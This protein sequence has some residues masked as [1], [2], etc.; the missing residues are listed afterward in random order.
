MVVVSG[1]VLW[2]GNHPLQY[3][4]CWCGGGGGCLSVSICQWMRGSPSL[5]PR[6]T[7]GRPLVAYIYPH[8]FLVLPPLREWSL[9]YSTVIPLLAAK[10]P[11]GS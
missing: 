10:P 4:H 9:M 6:G 5:T 3:V 2:W 7:P 11:A 1:W 8:E